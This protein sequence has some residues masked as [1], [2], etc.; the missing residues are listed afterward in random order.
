MSIYIMKANVTIEMRIQ[1]GINAAN[2]FTNIFM[3]HS[4]SA[5]TH[6]KKVSRDDSSLSGGYTGSD[7]S[8]HSFSKILEAEIN[9]KQAPAECHTVTY[10]N[11]LKLRTFL[12]QTREYQ[13]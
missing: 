9:E 8:T 10:G 1:G 13:Y 7:K 5:I 11:D 4:V 3:V 2:G 12:Y 6:T